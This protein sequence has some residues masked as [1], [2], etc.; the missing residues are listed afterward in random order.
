[1]SETEG[2]KPNSQE[3]PPLQVKKRPVQGIQEYNRY[4]PGEQHIRISDAI[5]FGRRRSNFPKC[6]GCQFN[7]DE[8]K[9]RPV[10]VPVPGA[11]ASAEEADRLRVERLFREC[12]VLGTYPDVLDAEMAWRIGL[13]AS[14]FFKSELRGYDRSQQEKATAVVGTDMRNSSKE[15]AA[16]LIEG[17]RSGG[18]PVIEI[19]MIDTPQ[20]YF[21][22]NRL[23]ACGGVQVTGGSRPANYNGFKLCGQKGRTI[24]S[25]TGLVKISKT[26]LN[27][28]RHIASQMPDPREVDLSAPYREYVRG[29]LNNPAAGY[30]TEHPFKLVVDASNG[31]AGRWLPIVFDGVGWLEITPLNFEHNGEFAHDPD[32]LIEDNLRP[33]QERVLRVKAD[34]GVCFDG[35]ADCCIFVDNTGQPVRAD[36]IAILLA[37]RLLRSCSGHSVIYDLRS[38]RALPEEIKKAGGLPRRE[39]GSQAFVKK[40]ISDAKAVFASELSGRYYYRDNFYCESSLITLACLLNILVESGRPLDELIAPVRRYA[41]SGER[42]L[43]LDGKTDVVSRLSEK[44]SHGSI[45]YLDGITVIFEDWWFNARPSADKSFVE[46]NVEAVNEAMLKAKLLELS[47]ALGAPPTPEREQRGT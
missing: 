19:G 40:A 41:R 13:A 47:Q 38:T 5:C 7:D 24:S 22:V 33:L 37:R 43:R 42:R 21:A 30:N 39:R 2:P 3:P 1:M 15:L 36:L 6:A 46:L 34:L 32:P 11:A 28:T 16:S 25:E 9:D 10:P 17:L 18:S 20:L 44:Y 23:G 14:L 12:D 35:D 8:R 4:C 31:M 29:F 26:V 45:N 27:T